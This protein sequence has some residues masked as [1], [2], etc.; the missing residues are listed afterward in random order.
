MSN[1]SSSD[2]ERIF[3][4]IFLD[5]DIVHYLV[6]YDEEIFDNQDV[7]INDTLTSDQFEKKNVESLRNLFGFPRSNFRLVISTNVIEEIMKKGD[8]HH[9]QYVHE[10]KDYCDVINEHDGNLQIFHDR[11]Q[12]LLIEF[13][14]RIGFLSNSDKKLII[15]AVRLQ[16]K[17]FMTMNEKL[18]KNK[19]QIKNLTG[20]TLIRP[21]EFWDL[22]RP[23]MSLLA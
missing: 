5:T 15:D 13:D 16:C 14:T 22:V 12:Q 2:L 19:I 20:I 11:D 23:Y 7:Q 21:Y 4:R 3:S 1:S 9:T 8:A 10:L 6:E 18:L 17:Y